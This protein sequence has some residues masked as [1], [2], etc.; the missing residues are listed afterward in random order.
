MNLSGFAIYKQGVLLHHYLAALQ[1]EA[2]GARCKLVLGTFNAIVLRLAYIANACGIAVS[3]S[4]Y[5]QVERGG[6]IGR[7]GGGKGSHLA[8]AIS[9][10][11]TLDIAVVAAVAAIKRGIGGSCRGLQNEVLVT[12]V[13]MH[14]IGGDA[15]LVLIHPLPYCS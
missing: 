13:A 11:G 7:N 6:G 12:T 4:G 10:P 8:L 15:Q 1:L 5:W 14:M 2:E 9:F 3:R